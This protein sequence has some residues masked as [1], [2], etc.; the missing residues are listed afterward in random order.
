AAGVPLV[1]FAVAH[2]LAVVGEDVAVLLRAACELG[3]AVALLVGQTPRHRL[4]EP[5][6]VAHPA[7]IAA[8]EVVG[9][10]AL[11]AGDVA[12]TEFAALAVLLTALRGGL[13]AARRRRYQKQR[14]ER[15]R[16]TQRGQDELLVHG[17]SGRRQP[18]GF[19]FSPHSR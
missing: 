4:A 6:G 5:E 7:F 17:H 12:A 9:A 8:R 10:Q 19:S 3:P 11:S 15:Q 13:G 1:G 18:A 16:N 2:G 14:G